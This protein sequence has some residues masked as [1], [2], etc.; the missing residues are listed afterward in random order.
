MGGFEKLS[1][2]RNLDSE[3]DAKT[4]FGR[5]LALQILMDHWNPTQKSPIDRVL[6]NNIDAVCGNTYVL[7]RLKREVMSW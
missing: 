3:R 7:L 2:E 5:F 4:N 1:L 6:Y